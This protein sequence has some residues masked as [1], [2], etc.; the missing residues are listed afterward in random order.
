MG[1]RRY[2]ELM[3]HFERRHSNAE[4]SQKWIEGQK[5]TKETGRVFAEY[6]DRAER[7]IHGEALPSLRDILKREADFAEGD[8]AGSHVAKL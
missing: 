2:L 1:P 3:T 4:T 5:V 6:A 7:G 8:A